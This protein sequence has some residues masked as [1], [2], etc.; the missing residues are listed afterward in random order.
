MLTDHDK[1]NYSHVFVSSPD[2]SHFSQIKQLLN[3]NV[4]RK[5]CTHIL[6]SGM[7]LGSSFDTDY[8]FFFFS[9][10]GEQGTTIQPLGGPKI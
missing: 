8:F 7:S 9:L 5:L 6:K 3:H 4:V 2:F 10:R 1:N